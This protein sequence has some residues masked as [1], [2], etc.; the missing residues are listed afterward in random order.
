VN[1]NASLI[2]FSSIK[3]NLDSDRDCQD[4][5]FELSVFNADSNTTS[6]I[7]TGLT[8][9]KSNLSMSDDGR[10][11]TFNLHPPGSRGIS[12]S[13]LYDRDQLQST[14]LNSENF[15]LASVIS[16]DGSTI[17]FTDVTALP[18]KIK[19][20]DRISGIETPI[21][22]G[23]GGDEP[24]SL[25]GFAA[26]SQDGRYTAFISTASNLVTSDDNRHDDIFVYDRVSGKTIL[27]SAQGPC[28]KVRSNEEFVTGPP[29][30][31]S[32]GR[33][34]PSPLRCLSG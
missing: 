12:Y 2:A 6:S 11:I 29:V 10:F 22:N 27:V 17:A 25:S 9:D 20:R 13:Y 24:K 7:D 32:D 1:A 23:V 5:Y 4:C 8:G 26:L 21:S 19:L 18:V 33:D 16:G 34:P 15:S 31:S 14:P 28:R 3:V 30:I